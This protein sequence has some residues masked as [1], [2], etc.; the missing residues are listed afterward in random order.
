MKRM[1]WF[2]RDLLYLVTIVVVLLGVQYLLERSADYYPA[3]RYYHRILVLMPAYSPR[4]ASQLTLSRPPRCR[5][6]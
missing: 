6:R 3:M 1:P 4:A 2:V 5:P